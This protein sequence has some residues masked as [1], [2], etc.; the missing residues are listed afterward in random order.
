[1]LGAC[2]FRWKA[3]L[4]CSIGADK[5]SSDQQK[6]R[7]PPH[8][9]EKCQTHLRLIGE[10]HCLSVASLDVTVAVALAIP[11]SDSIS[12]AIRE[13]YPEIGVDSIKDICTICIEQIPI[14]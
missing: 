11:S 13:R 4:P 6:E 10:F 2:I 1:M 5:L 12:H 7:S 3:K 14:M 9:N 8:L